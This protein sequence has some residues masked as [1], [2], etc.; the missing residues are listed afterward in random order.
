MGSLNNCMSMN[1]YN[2]SWCT[3]IEL[4]HTLLLV[5]TVTHKLFLGQ[6]N[7]VLMGRKTWESIPAKFRPLPNRINVVISRTMK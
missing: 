4:D 5:L 7:A 2:C 1:N 3:T 6:Q